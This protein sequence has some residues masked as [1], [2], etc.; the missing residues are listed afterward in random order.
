MTELLFWLAM[1]IQQ[2]TLLDFQSRSSIK[3]SQRLCL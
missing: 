2:R 3:K 1:G